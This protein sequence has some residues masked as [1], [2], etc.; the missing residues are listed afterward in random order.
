MVTKENIND[1]DADVTYTIHRSTNC[2]ADWVRKLLG[3]YNNRD[4]Y[5]DNKNLRIQILLLY[6]VVGVKASWFVFQ[7]LGKQKEPTL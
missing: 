5:H 1:R 6:T 3:H 4:R 2:A 7:L